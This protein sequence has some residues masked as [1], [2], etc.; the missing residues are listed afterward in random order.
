MSKRKSKSKCIRKR[1]T[2]STIENEPSKRILDNG[3]HSATFL[4]AKNPR[5]VVLER[6]EHFQP[7]TRQ[8]PSIIFHNLPSSVSYQERETLHHAYI[9][10][11]S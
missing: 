10:K 5:K 2:N 6:R 1:V 3:D 7:R 8:N 4:Q 9:R 11:L